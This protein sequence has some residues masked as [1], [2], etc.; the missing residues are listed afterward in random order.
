ME[1]AKWKKCDRQLEEPIDIIG[2]SIEVVSV[3]RVRW[4]RWWR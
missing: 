4:W 2:K 3:G 1:E